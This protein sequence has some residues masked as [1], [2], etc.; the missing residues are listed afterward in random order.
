MSHTPVTALGVAAAGAGACLSHGRNTLG[1]SKAPKHGS[2]LPQSRIHQL[3]VSMN[4]HAAG[5]GEWRAPGG[6]PAG[7]SYTVA[8]IAAAVVR[9]VRA[10]QGRSREQFA[11]QVGL[12]LGVLV[13]VEDAAVPVWAL[14]YDQFAALAEAAGAH[15]LQAGEVFWAAGS[16]DLLLTSV[17]N[18]DHPVLCDA[19]TESESLGRVRMLLRWALHGTPPACES[20]PVPG[21]RPLLGEDEQRLLRDR[22]QALATSGSTDA[23]V[24][25]QLLSLAAS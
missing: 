12:G 8:V 18:G 14:P 25:T 11:A 16:C 4:D 10:A 24:G 1:A 3:G 9:A 7:E 2:H 5:V 21:G 20:L 15:D 19:L 6:A 22:L 13:S 17:L 23:W